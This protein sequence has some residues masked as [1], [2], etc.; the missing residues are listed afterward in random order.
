[1]QLLRKNVVANT[2]TEFKFDVSCTKFLVKNLTDDFIYACLGDEFDEN[3]SSIILSGM[4]EYLEI[5]EKLEN[6]TTSITI[7]A[8]VAGDIEVQAL[9]YTS[10][11]VD[12]LEN[13]NKILSSIFGKDVRQAIHDSIQIINNKVNKTEKTLRNLIKNSTDS[14]PSAAEIVEA[15]GTYDLL[16]DRLES[17]DTSIS[18][19][20]NDIEEINNSNTSKKD[21]E[22]IKNQEIKTYTV[23]ENE[24]TFLLPENYEQDSI[25]EVF[26]NDTLNSNFT[27]QEISFV[28]CIVLNENV[29]NC[30]VKI[31]CTNFS[32]TLKNLIK[33]LITDNS[34]VG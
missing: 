10:L 22:Y 21:Y 32:E 28:D 4:S 29:S 25:I 3:S 7:R 14:T 2:T 34:S 5:N 33:K 19:I 6:P 16:N 23:T 27:I 1:M 11:K 15:R 12:I 8:K 18:T 24:S 31:Q 30:T 9:T 17:I 20:N 13:L 26:I